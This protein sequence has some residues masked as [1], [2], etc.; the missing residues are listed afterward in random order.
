MSHALA[1]DP[2]PELRSAPLGARV[3]VAEDEAIISLALEDM[4]GDLGCKVVGTASRVSDALAFVAA[5]DVDVA[6]L[7]RKL[8][9]G[10]IDPVVA[11]LAARATPVI[12]ASGYADGGSAEALFLPKP[13]TAAGLRQVL[14][15]ALAQ[16]DA[17]PARS[18]PL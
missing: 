7:D 14:V 15:Q 2:S 16:R 6:I 10:K 12:L 11:V 9:D 18:A 4:L 8:V 17:L 5:H 1:P 13:Y 3:F